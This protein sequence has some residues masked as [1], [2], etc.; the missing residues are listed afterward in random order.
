[1]AAYFDRVVTYNPMSCKERN[2]LTFLLTCCVGDAVVLLQGIR[3]RRKD[4]HPV[5]YC[6]LKGNHVFVNGY[7][8]KSNSHACVLIALACKKFKLPSVLAIG[9]LTEGCLAGRALL[10]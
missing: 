7:S 10:L 1:M 8:D 6:Q 9:W 3:L 2:R 5:A 4:N